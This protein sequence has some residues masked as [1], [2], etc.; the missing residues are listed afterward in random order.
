MSEKKITTFA[1][2]D[3]EGKLVHYK[4]RTEAANGKKKTFC[5]RHQVNGK[6]VYS[7]RDEKELLYNLPNLIKAKV[8]IIVEGENKVECLEKLGLT[9]TSLDSGAKSP[10]LP[11]YTEYFKGKDKVVILP[12]AD[13]PGLAYAETVA[14][15]LKDT[16]PHIKVVHLSGLDQKEDTIQWIEKR[17]GKPLTELRA[18]LLKEIQ[19]APLWKPNNEIAFESII[20]LEEYS[21]EPFPA[22]L[23]PTWLGKFCE[24][25]SVETQTP[26]ELAALMSLSILATA[27]AKKFIVSVKE[28]YMEPLNLWTCASLETGTRKT[29]VV[30]KC[31]QPI[32]EWEKEKAL[33]LRDKI[34]EANSKR[35]SEE[36]I[37]NSMRSKLGRTE[38]IE[39]DS[40]LN[41]IVEKEKELTEVPTKPR[42]F[43]D[44]ITP[45]KLASIMQENAGRIAIISDE[46]AALR[47]MSGHYST[48]GNP[49][50]EVFCQGYS[51]FDLRVDRKS[52]DSTSISSPA[53][54]IG[55][56]PQPFVLQKLAK[57]EAFIEQGVF[58][59]FWY[60]FPSSNVGYR[61]NKPKPTSEEAKEAY[62]KGIK[63]ILDLTP[64]K[65]D[66]GD[67]IPYT[68]TLSK[69]AMDRF[70]QF[71][72]EVE[73]KMRE[74]EELFFI[75]HW[76]SKLPGNTVRVAGL[77]HIA[78]HYAEQPWAK[79]I[80]QE[81]LVSALAF[82]QVLTG[83]ALAVFDYL[84]V[85]PTLERAMKILKWIKRKG[86]S[87]FS[88][89]DCH[90]ENKSYFKRAKDLEEPLNVLEERHYIKALKGEKGKTGRPTDPYMVN[91]ELS[92]GFKQ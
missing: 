63:A 91:P 7:R 76:A 67:F 31:R 15:G 36:A 82:S 90:Y 30:Y 27:S 11:E 55:I 32:T 75:R 33:E 86:R 78:K 26:I 84:E 79:E 34:K 16:V 77:F 29:P 22:D 42:L 61:S 41:D 70:E 24:E 17:N 49:V 38:G 28:G 60:A 6:W 48:K 62:L 18:E 85:S 89:R 3:E 40:L 51:G 47:V 43:V 20:P 69:E 68:L 5:F 88:K 71:Q 65:D 87:E 45:E 19:R 1:Y 64:D 25:L 44:D 21:F 46:G 54:T 66:H 13:T 92:K 83:H 23:L 50:L 14:N 72:D 80:S 57:D 4:D 81:T 56:S 10:W 58:A 9:A 39:L 52:G 12:D 73:F 8:P 74:G 35:K 53:V 37:I 2:L 59:R